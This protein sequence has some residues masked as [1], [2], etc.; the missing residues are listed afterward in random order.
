MPEP[1][2]HSD[3]AGCVHP[4]GLFGNTAAFLYPAGFAEVANLSVHLPCR[5]GHFEGGRERPPV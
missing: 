2:A 1:D 4:K 3:K 5:C